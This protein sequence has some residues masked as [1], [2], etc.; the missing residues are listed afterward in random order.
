MRTLTDA[1]LLALGAGLSAVG[2]ALI[3][4]GSFLAGQGLAQF[5]P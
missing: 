2:C 5:L 1:G 4:T 3:L